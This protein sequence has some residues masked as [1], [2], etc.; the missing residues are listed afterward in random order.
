MG[1]LKKI[2]NVFKIFMIIL[3]IF[4]IVCF[5]SIVYQKKVMKITLPNLFG[6]S[7][8]TIVSGSMEPNIKIGDYVI[9]R[10]NAGYE[11][12]DVVLFKRGNAY[13]AH[14]VMEIHDDYI[15]TKGDN[16]ETVDVDI[17]KDTVVGPV[18]KVING[19]GT[20]IMFLT[21]YKFLIFAIVVLIIILI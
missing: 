1:V 17:P 15:V 7:G 21:Q 6:Y 8:G 5:S 3:L 12:G 16:N 14:R 13:I 19:L 20:T 18:V 10:V 4:I 11:V 9:A 2:L